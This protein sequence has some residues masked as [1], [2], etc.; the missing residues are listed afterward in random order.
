MMEWGPMLDM[1][2]CSAENS[3]QG[4]PLI[5]AAISIVGKS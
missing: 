2:S 3:E 1:L 4:P 5:A